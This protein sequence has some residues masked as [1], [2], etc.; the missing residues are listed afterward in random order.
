MIR[1]TA[2]ISNVM[3]SEFSNLPISVLVV[4]AIICGLGLLVCLDC[5]KWPIWAGLLTNTAYRVHFSVSVSAIFS[6]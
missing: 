5:Q 1:F 6:F 2:Q 4:D 3:F